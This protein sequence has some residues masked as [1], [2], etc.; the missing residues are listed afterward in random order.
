MASNQTKPDR[1]AREPDSPASLSQK[2]EK[3]VDFSAK[4]ALEV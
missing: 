3:Q 2:S 4:D 1:Y